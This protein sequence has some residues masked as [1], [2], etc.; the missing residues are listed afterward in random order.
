MTFQ[1]YGLSSIMPHIKKLSGTPL[2][3]LRILG[4]DNIRI[5]YFI[6]HKE[7]ILVLHGFVKKSQK[8]PEKELSLAL[9]RY[10]DYLDRTPKI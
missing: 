1:K 2:W 8:T 4:G 7:A 5:V 10:K 3:E 6:P 9:K